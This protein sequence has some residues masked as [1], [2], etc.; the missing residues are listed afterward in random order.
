MI[1]T[2]PT[3]HRGLAEPN[4]SAAVSADVPSYVL[5]VWMGNHPVDKKSAARWGDRPAT[6]APCASNLVVGRGNAVRE[7]AGS[8]ASNADATK[9]VRTCGGTISIE[10]ACTTKMPDRQA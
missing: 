9:S 10:T 7:S 6:V 5:A 2:L 3:A 4:N 1:H 8:S